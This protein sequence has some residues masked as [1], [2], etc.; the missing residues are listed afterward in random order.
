MP[1]FQACRPRYPT[2]PT[3]DRVM[4]R[5]FVILTMLATLILMPSMAG[6][7]SR[8]LNQYE[9]MNIPPLRIGSWN[10]QSLGSN[11]DE[12]SYPLLASVISAF[13]IVALQEIVRDWSIPQ[14]EAEVERVSG[15]TWSSLASP[16]SGREGEQEMLLFLWRDKLVT[17]L[18]AAVAF[19]DQR[20]M[21]E[22]DPFSNRFAMKRGDMVFTLATV[23]IT[24]AGAAEAAAE[25]AALEGYWRWLE[26]V[27]GSGNTLLLGDFRLPSTHEAFQG[28]TTHAR[29]MT[30][31]PSILAPEDGRY[32]AAADTIW[33]SHDA[34]MI[35]QRS[36]VLGYPKLLG[37]SHADA[38]ARISDHAPAYMTGWPP[39]PQ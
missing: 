29:A 28:L 16:A 34:D 13:D 31:M 5:L 1:C 33:L 14:I 10:V 27:Y 19:P 20:N 30:D 7:G 24:Q 18:D 22:H 32:T 21:F 12:K 37:I 26:H 4:P 6:A 11:E 25:I 17:S 3:K 39:L 15:E 36:G 8:Q 9:L 2:L 35:V 23:H 38:I